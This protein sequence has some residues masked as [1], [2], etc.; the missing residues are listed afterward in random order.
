MQEK[1]REQ[2][3]EWL[4]FLVLKYMYKAEFKTVFSNIINFHFRIKEND[5]FEE[6]NSSLR[7]F[8]VKLNYSKYIFFM[9]MN[10]TC[11]VQ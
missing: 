3:A 1:S 10:I 9:N 4:N 11:E 7:Y 2:F 6:K 5:K 8:H